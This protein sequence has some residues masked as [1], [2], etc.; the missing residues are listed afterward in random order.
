M[1]GQK[2]RI[3]QITESSFRM[4]LLDMGCVPGTIIYLSFR[5]PLGDPMAYS[6]NGFTLGMRKEQAQS[7]EIELIY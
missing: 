5:A 3:V 7:V 1:P 6:I 4:K 2:A